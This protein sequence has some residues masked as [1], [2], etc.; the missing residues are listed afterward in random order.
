MEV[1]GGAETAATIITAY[2]GAPLGTSGFILDL[3]GD[4]RLPCMPPFISDMG[5]VIPLS[6][7]QPTFRG[8]SVRVTVSPASLAFSLH[9]SSL[10]KIYADMNTEESIAAAA[11]MTANPGIVRAVAYD[12]PIVMPH[13]IIH[14]LES[15]LDYS[16]ICEEAG[17]PNEWMTKAVTTDGLTT[18]Q[19]IENNCNKVATVSV[20]CL[21]STALPSDVPVSTIVGTVTDAYTEYRIELRASLILGVPKYL[22]YAAINNGTAESVDLELI[23]FERIY[24][25]TNGLIELIAA[26][27]SQVSLNDILTAEYGSLNPG[28]IIAT[29]NVGPFDSNT[30]EKYDFN[31][32]YVFPSGWPNLKQ[33]TREDTMLRGLALTEG[34]DVRTFKSFM[35]TLLLLAPSDELFEIVPVV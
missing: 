34:L 18:W 16:S 3:A 25:Q 31:W 17:E 22:M 27:D 6:E 9:S 12:E 33:T 4:L 14:Q 7:F 5:F 19:D 23:E 1:F 21:K 26:P 11:I 29:M 30:D 35:T 20:S 15:Y 8:E 28:D 13:D 24:T 2:A 10:L 32:G